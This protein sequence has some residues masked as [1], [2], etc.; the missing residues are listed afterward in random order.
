MSE[1]ATSSLS[2][3]Q[4]RQALERLL[5]SHAFSRAD[6]LRRFLRYIC[7]T[8]IAGHPDEITEHLI[9]TRALGRAADY[10]PGDDSSVRNRAHALRQKLDEYYRTEGPEAP[11][12][13]ELRKGS[14][15]P[16]FVERTESLPPAPPP[17]IATPPPLVVVPPMPAPIPRH[18]GPEWLGPFLAGAGLSALL[19]LGAWGWSQRATADQATLDSAWGEML[20]PGANVIVCLGSPP[21]LLL[22]S[23]RDGT[24]PPQPRMFGAPAEIQQWYEGLGMMDGG[25]KLYM[26]STMNAALVGDALA[27]ARAVRLLSRAGANVQLLPEW[28]TRPLALRGRNLLLVGSPNYSPYAARI[29][30]KMPLTVWQDPSIKEEVIAEDLTDGNAR[31]VFRPK[32]DQRGQYSQVYGLL[33]VLPSHPHED[34]P[35][36][37]AIFS[38]ITSAGPQAAMEFFSSPSILRE[39]AARFGGN[40]LPRSY[41]VVISAGVDRSLALTWTYAHH[42]VI[43]RVPSLD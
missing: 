22:K 40:R 19:A 6:Q 10:I 27:A 24:L 32:R 37:T 31:R 35:E 26:S 3:E 39:L 12:R 13:V 29:L 21:T 5:N 14:Y 7:E 38:G 4:K 28:G 2:P 30:A 41:Q 9:A 15:V 36:T 42:R 34:S 33:T 11:V 1:L 16:I 18:R 17:P 43:D 25:G 23:F 20:H 8:E